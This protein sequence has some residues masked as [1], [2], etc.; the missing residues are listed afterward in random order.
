MLAPAYTHVG[1]GAAAA[2]GEL[3]ASLM[4]LAVAP[5]LDITQ[6]RRAI[7][8]HLVRD[9]KIGADAELAEIAQRFAV[10]L[11][12]GRTEDSVWEELKPLIDRTGRRFTRISYAVA[13]SQA[14]AVEKS[15]RLLNFQEVDD[16]GVGIAQGDHPRFGRRAIWTV[17]FWAHRLT[18]RAGSGRF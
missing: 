6:A 12:L 9:K 16:L 8:A 14:L 1:A 11:A 15:D 3:Y 4:Y 13:R 17:V 2:A 10:Q 7:T 18:P 5:R